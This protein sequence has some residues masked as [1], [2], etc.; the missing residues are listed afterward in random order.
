[1][2][3]WLYVACW[4]LFLLNVAILFGGSGSFLNVLGA[5]ACGIA[6]VMTPAKSGR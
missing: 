5:V 3:T 6:I 4:V 2:R 1:M